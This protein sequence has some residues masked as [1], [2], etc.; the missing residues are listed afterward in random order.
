M[1]LSTTKSHLTGHGYNSNI[2]FNPG[3]ILEPKVGQL[4]PKY[5]KPGTF[6]D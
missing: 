6:S 1:K 2:F 3:I 4:D 5:D